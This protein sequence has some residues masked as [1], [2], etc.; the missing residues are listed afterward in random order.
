MSANHP[1][2]KPD[3]AISDEQRASGG[4][5]QQGWTGAIHPVE[6]SDT[7]VRL[8]SEDL[9]ALLAFFQLLE[10]WDQENKTI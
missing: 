9:A 1:S 10:K 8:N 6:R 2:S 7:G 3:L 5:L 4:Q